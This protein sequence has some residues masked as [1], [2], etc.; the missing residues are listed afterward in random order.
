MHKG[1]TELAIRYARMALER[2]H[3]C[4]GAYFALGMSLFMTDRLEEAAALAERA[5][6]ISGDDYNVYLA[7]NNTFKKLGDREKVKRIRSQHV[8]IL[9]WHLEWAPENV[10][11]R[12]LL[13]CGYATL[14]DPD[15]AIEELERAVASAPNDASTLFNAAC[16]YGTLGQKSEALLMLKRAV[17]NG[18]WHFDTIAREPDFT[19]LHGEPEFQLLIERQND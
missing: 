15:K 11:A 10:R 14:G 19:I 5:I 17:N 9:Q 18:Y 4:E 13:A 3:D 2:K 7:F 1:S 16:T 12:I 6:E 8:R